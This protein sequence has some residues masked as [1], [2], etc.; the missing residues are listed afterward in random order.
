MFSGK[1]NLMNGVAAT[2]AFTTCESSD[3][4]PQST[5]V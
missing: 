5:D 1:V 2:E 4:V 3:E